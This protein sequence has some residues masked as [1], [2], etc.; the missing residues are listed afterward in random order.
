MKQTTLA[1]IVL[2]LA[3][4]PLSAQT[5]AQANAQ[6]DEQAYNTLC[7][8]CH[9]LSKKKGEQSLAPPVFAVKSHVIKAYPE[10]EDFIQTVVDWV[11]EPNLDTALMPGAIRKFGL[12]PKLPY[13]ASEVR[14]AAAYMYDTAFELP[15]WYKKHYKEKHGEDIE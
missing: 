3:S 12:M 13:A 9:L 1:A 2:A 4:S 5:E 7:L 10:R 15:E 6:T 8:S 14:Q 11:E